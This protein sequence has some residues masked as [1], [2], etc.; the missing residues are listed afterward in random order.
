[1]YVTKSSINAFIILMLRCDMHAEIGIS[2]STTRVTMSTSTVGLPTD[3][4]V[5]DTELAQS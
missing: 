1:M 5:N 3:D 4:D 2:E